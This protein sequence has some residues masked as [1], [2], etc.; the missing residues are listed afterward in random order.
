[1]IDRTT[2][3]GRRH[4]TVNA[5]F[6]HGCRCDDARKARTRYEKRRI[7]GLNPPG[8]VP[9]LGTIRRLRALVAIGY[10]S[11]WLAEE[12]GWKLT[13]VL[14][15]TNH[16]A[17]ESRTVHV[18]TR[19]QVAALFERRCMIPGG[20]DRSRARARKQGWRP[21]L[22]WD[23]IDNPAEKP[24]QVD[25]EIRSESYVD[26]AAVDRCLNGDLPGAH[27]TVKAE[28]VRVLAGRRKPDREIAEL[29][30]CTE[31]TVLRIR[32]DFGIAAGNPEHN[33]NPELR[34]SWSRI[35]GKRDSRSKASQA[36]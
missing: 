17:P 12:L 18:D 27:R 34:D 3:P 9:A 22:A 29:I 36:A 16:R 2:C 26:P 23:D 8:Y 30:G 31:R 32:K 25:P 5:Y 13:V 14:R 24:D 19:D 6:K 4:G 28:A 20:N 33:P 10:T 15:L 21:P 35:L 7:A 11:T 1:M